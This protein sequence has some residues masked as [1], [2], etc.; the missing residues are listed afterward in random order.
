MSRRRHKHPMTRLAIAMGVA[1]HNVE[2]A[3]FRKEAVRE[4][5]TIPVSN[6]EIGGGRRGEMARLGRKTMLA[7]ADMP[8]ED[9]AEA[10]IVLRACRDA[11][12][13]RFEVTSE[14]RLGERRHRSA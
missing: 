13:S 9:R 4:A 6:A 11:V 2:A 3:W 7:L 1:A 14:T 12:M 5:Q 10:V 8:A